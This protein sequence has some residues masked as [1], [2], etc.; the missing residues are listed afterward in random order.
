MFSAHTINYSTPVI[1]L[2][3][4]FVEILFSSLVFFLGTMLEDPGE[5]GV[6]KHPVLDG[7][8]AIHL[9]HIIVSEPFTHGGQQFP[10]TVL[11]DEPAVVV[12]KA[13]KGVLDDIFRV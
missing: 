1:I 3:L 4:L 9:I 7:S 6:V 11:V 5:L 10:E 2:A 8:L 12:I 13:T